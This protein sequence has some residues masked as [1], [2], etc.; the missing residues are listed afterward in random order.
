M[1]DTQEVHSKEATKGPFEED[2]NGLSKRPL[3]R[4]KPKAHSKVIQEVQSKEVIGQSK[5]NSREHSKE[6]KCPHTFKFKK[7]QVSMTFATLQ[8][9][10]HG[11]ENI[12]LWKL[13]ICLLVPSLPLYISRM[14]ASQKGHTKGPF[15]RYTRRTI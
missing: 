9:F 1:K 11:L 8:N 6:P 13:N 7:G 3:R 2:A 5:S 4:R 15:K 14:L 10:I 12:F